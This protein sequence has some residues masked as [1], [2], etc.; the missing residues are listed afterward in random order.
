MTDYLAAIYGT[1]GTPPQQSLEEEDV[2]GNISSNPTFTQAVA[3][4]PTKIEAEAL[5][6]WKI[7]SLHYVQGVHRRLAKKTTQVEKLRDTSSKGQFTADLSSLIPKPFQWPS[8][9]DPALAQ[10]YDYQHREEIVKVL[11]NIQ[12]DR[13]VKMEEDLMKFEII[14]E[15][16]ILLGHCRDKLEK[17]CPSVYQSDAHCS[18]LIAGLTRD[19][20]Q[21]KANSSK[22]PQTP[23]PS[24]PAPNAATDPS[25]MILEQLKAI[26]TEMATMKAQMAR[27]NTPKSSHPSSKAANQKAQL[28]QS[29]KTITPREIDDDV[30]P[31]KLV[32]HGRSK[33]PKNEGRAGKSPQKN[34][35]HSK[36]RSHSQGTRAGSPSPSGA[37]QNT[38]LPTKWN[39][40][41]PSPHPNPT[42][43][44]ISSDDGGKQRGKGKHL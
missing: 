19:L 13:L 29:K 10:S 16:H 38:Y 5:N 12:K 18:Q 21:T 8:T 6:K 42:I 40:N 26:Q 35:A 4:K 41:S 32:R 28:N 43:G 39:S 27:I 34:S 25:S 14:N 7:E 24:N 15:D 23:T 37:R 3:Y 17:V 44:R 33:S 1:A 2:M 11:T 22:K 30:P 9:I 20:L 36:S 31:F